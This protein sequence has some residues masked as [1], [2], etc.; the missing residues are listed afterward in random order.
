MLKKIFKGKKR[1]KFPNFKF[2][3]FLDCWIKTWGQNYWFSTIRIKPVFKF[4]VLILDSAPKVLQILNF[5]KNCNKN[6][7]SKNFEKLK[8]FRVNFVKKLAF[9]FLKSLM[10]N[11]FFLIKKKTN[12]HVLILIVRNSFKARK[13]QVSKF[14]VSG[15]FVTAEQ[16][17]GIK[18][19]NFRKF[20]DDKF[21]NS[22][23]FSFWIQLLEFLKFKCSKKS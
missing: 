9:W 8:Y 11:A 3:V 1:A 20:K 7:T 6:E 14:Q 18:I 16:K 19:F 5:K 2:P 10:E 4:L 12:Y 23:S 17:S 21:L 15:F 22:L 13:I